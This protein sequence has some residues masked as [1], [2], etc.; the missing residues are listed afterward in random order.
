M[1]VMSSKVYYSQVD[2]NENTESIVRKILSLFHS[3]DLDSFINKNDLVGI[4]MHFGEE[5]NDTH[6]PP[7]FVSPIVEEIK[8][9][10]GTPFLTDTCVLYRSQRDNSANHILLAHRHGF[11]LDQIG[12]PIIIADGLIGNAERDIE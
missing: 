4:K 12:A 1:D 3:A 6:I 7:H 2:Q 8:K 9:R 11:S 10:E 5:G